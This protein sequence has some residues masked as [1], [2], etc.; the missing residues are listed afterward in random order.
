MKTT[1]MNFEGGVNKKHTTKTATA[2]EAEQGEYKK[3]NTIQFQSDGSPKGR[4]VRPGPQMN[5]PNGSK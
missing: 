5:F 2:G 4:S 1:S 3:P